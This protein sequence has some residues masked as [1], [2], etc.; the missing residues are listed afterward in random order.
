[1]KPYPLLISSFILFLAGI[2]CQ[3]SASAQIITFGAKGGL[4][5]PNLTSGD[6]GNPLSEG[7]SS[8]LGADAAV[9][10][11][12]HMSK[13]FSTTV[14]FEYCAQ[15][16]KKSGMQAFEVPAEYAAFVP[17]GTKYLYA[18]FKSEAKFDYMMLPVMA[19]VRYA[20]GS[21]P[22]SV[23]VSAGP[24][25]S[26]L[27]KAEQETRGASTIY[28]DEAGTQALPAGVVSFNADNNIRSDLNRYNVGGVGLVGFEFS[29]EP[30]AVFIEAGGNF[31]FIPIQKGS[32]H[33][34]N[35]TGAAVI[36]MGCSYT[37]RN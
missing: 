8:R 34:K 23:Y 1:M 22:F 20:F 5:V 28:L 15:G 10:A 2:L 33:G 29:L 7:Y 27:M 3:S 21:S 35:Y 24:F 37:F 4:S 16:G 31:G 6:T 30:Y 19:R 9:F 12:Y 13:I 18:D 36:T 26:I 25:V 32:S 11:E 17:P 14:G